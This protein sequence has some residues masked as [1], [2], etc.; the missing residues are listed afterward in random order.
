VL[1]VAVIRCPAVQTEAV[2]LAAV[3]L[4]GRMVADRLAHDRLLECQASVVRLDQWVFRLRRQAGPLEA[5]K[6]KALAAELVLIAAN[7]LAAAAVAPAARVFSQ[8]PAVER[9]ARR[10]ALLA[11]ACPVLLAARLVR[12]EVQVQGFLPLVVK[13]AAVDRVPRMEAVAMRVARVMVQ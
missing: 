3:P 13:V 8:A 11:E 12:P 9:M 5:F 10:A 6:A 1:R 7:P 2:Q 4:A